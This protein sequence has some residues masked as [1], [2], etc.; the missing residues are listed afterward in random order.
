[1]DEPARSGESAH[2][3]LLLT[4]G[5]VFK[6]KDLHTLHSLIILWSMRNNNTIR[7]GGRRTKTN[8]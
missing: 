7:H 1:M 6:F 2:I 3:A 8:H 5:H 4:V